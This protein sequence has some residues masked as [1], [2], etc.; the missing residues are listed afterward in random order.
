MVDIHQNIVDRMYG[1]DSAVES[2]IADSYCN[3]DDGRQQENERSEVVQIT[4]RKGSYREK[5]DDAGQR[6]PFQH[7]FNVEQVGETE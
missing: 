1:S 3:D 5:G 4:G 2:Q 6:I 7:L